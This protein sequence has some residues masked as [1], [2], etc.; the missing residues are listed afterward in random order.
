[1]A[2]RIASGMKSIRLL[3]IG[4][5]LLTLAAAFVT[6]CVHFHTAWPWN[7][8]VHEDGRRTLRQTIF[9]FEHALG[10]LPLELLLA[11]AVSGA[12]L[13][14]RQPAIV[15]AQTFLPVFV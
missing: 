14:C 9:Y 12:L 3:L 8:T 11:A 5:P 15:V 7:V 13:R 4:V 2:G 10:E 1:M 6:I